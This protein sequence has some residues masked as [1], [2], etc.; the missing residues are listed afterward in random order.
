VKESIIFH[1]LNKLEERYNSMIAKIW[2]PEDK[3]GLLLKLLP[4]VVTIQDPET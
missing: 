4:S 3:R 2:V 1:T